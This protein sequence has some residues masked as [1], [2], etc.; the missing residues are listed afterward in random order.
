M[1]HISDGD[2]SEKFT[3]IVYSLRILE[4]TKAAS[5]FFVVVISLVQFIFSKCQDEHL[6]AVIYV[7]IIGLYLLVV[8]VCRSHVDEQKLRSRQKLMLYS[9]GLDLVLVI[10]AIGALGDVLFRLTTLTTLM[11][12]R[13]SPTLFFVLT[14]SGTPL[15]A[16]TSLSAGDHY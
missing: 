7:C 6:G 10:P 15:A 4:I 16:P 14:V 12:C 2:A 13:L 5:A 8:S 9:F 1:T 11:W 3:S